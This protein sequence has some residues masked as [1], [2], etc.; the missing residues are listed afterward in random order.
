[1]TFLTVVARG[2]IRRPVRTGLTLLGISIGIA[3]VVALVGIS[4]GFESSW[5]SGMKARGTDVVVSNLSSALTPKPFED[6]VRERITPLPHVAATC[7]ILVDLM[8]IESS[9]M[10]FVSAREW[11]GF[12]WENL[13]L[14][15]GRMPKD[16]MEPVV[17]LGRT[18]AEVLSKKIGDPIQ[19]ETRELTVAGIIDG[20][21]IVEDGS[22]ILS[23][24]LLQEITGNQGKINIIDVRVTPGTTEAEVKTLCQEINKVVPEG[25]AMPAG[26]N[27]G[28]SQAYKFIRAMSWGT[29]LLAVLVGVLGV[30]NTMLMTV[31]ERTQEICILLALGWKRSRIVRLILWESALLGFSGGVVGVIIGGIGVKLLEHT[32]AIRGLLEADLSPQLMLMSVLI[33]LVVG[34][35]SGLYPAWRSSRLPPGQALHG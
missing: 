24:P 30:M 4:R 32:P 19:I 11:G 35:I 27:I 5:A 26:D 1:M 10:M 9:S 21:A 8:G 3:A 20:G 17:I 16:A 7:T 22:V 34:V 15:A 14:T 23:L 12:S 31:F 18:A 6:K 33:S 28:N 2:L 25:K 29:S 13:K